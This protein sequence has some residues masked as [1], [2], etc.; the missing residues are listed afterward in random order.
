MSMRIL[1]IGKNGQLGRSL[2]RLIVGTKQASNFIFTEREELDLSNEDN[3]IRYFDNNTFDVIVNC[4][5]YTAVDKAET[6]QS[7]ANQ[8]NYLAVKSIAKISKRQRAKLI[9][10]STDYVFD[11]EGGRPYEEMDTTNPINVYGRTKLLGEKSIQENMP[12]D[13]IIIRVGWLYS[14]F[15]NNFV[16][17][18]LRIGK[19]KQEIYV[20]NDQVGSPT[21][22][23]NLAEVI[24]KILRNKAYF[25]NVRATELYHYSDKGS[26][27]WC[28]FAKEIF[29]FSSIDCQVK[30]ITTSQYKASA[31]RPKHTVLNTD[32]IER[33]FGIDIKKRGESLKAALKMKA[34]S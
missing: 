30:P 16:D 24:I 27:S 31:Q 19:R 28:E 6:E 17:T 22:S 2:Y 4:A 5:A 34:R 14:E 20:V 10:I 11:G 8:V 15:N 3:I 21:Y 18:M 32:K 12:T 13:A 9:H 7:L 1:V 26:L 23:A 25:E 33:Q 29:E